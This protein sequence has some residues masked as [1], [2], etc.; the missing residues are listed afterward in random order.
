[1][2]KYLHALG[3]QVESS[4][5]S[6]DA[7]ATLDASAL[8]QRS[9]SSSS[10]GFPQIDGD[11]RQRKRGRRGGHPPSPAFAATETDAIVCSS[12]IECLDHDVEEDFENRIHVDRG[13]EVGRVHL[14]VCR[15]MFEMDD[16]NIENHHRYADEGCVQDFSNSPEEI[17]RVSDWILKSSFGENRNNLVNRSLDDHNDPKLWK[18]SPSTTSESQSLKESQRV[19]KRP[20]GP[21]PRKAEAGRATGDSPARRRLHASAHVHST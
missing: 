18:I 15:G 20:S 11:V 9:S 14:R 1:M 21:T 19:S 17:Q 8:P 3:L 10:S 16:E 4:G 13:V 12:A 2:T 6:S 5:E 7:A